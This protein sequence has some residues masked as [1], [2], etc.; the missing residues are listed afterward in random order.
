MAIV[1]PMTTTPHYSKTSGTSTDL[2]AE[3]YTDC[4]VSLEALET[5]LEKVEFNSRDYSV[6]SFKAAAAERAAIFAKLAEVKAYLNNHL[7]AAL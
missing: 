6:E 2:L 5:N 4:I 7:E 1:G 3:Q